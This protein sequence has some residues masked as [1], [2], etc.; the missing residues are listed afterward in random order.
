[1]PKTFATVIE[2]GTSLG[3]HTGS[4]RTIKPE[5]IAGLPPCSATCP[6]G[7]NIQL[8]LSL[9]KAGKFREAWEVMVRDN[10]FPAIMGRICY[11][12]C[13][14]TCCRGQFDGSVNINMIERSI[15]DAAITNGWKFADSAQNSG[16]KIIVVGAGPGGLSAAYFLRK[17]G[18]EVTVYESRAKPGG[19]MRYGVPRY[20]LS[21][22][23]MDAEIKRIEDYGVK[24]I[25]GN[26]ISGIHDDIIGEFDALYAAI[27]AHRAS[28]TDVIMKNGAAVIDAIDL[29]RRLEETPMDLPS[30]GQKVFV[31]GGGNTAVDAA[32]TALRLGAESVKIIYRRTIND[33]P[34]HEIEINAALSE[35]IEILCLRTINSIDGNSILV[36]K[37]NYDEEFEILSKSGDTEVFQADS[38]IF[39]IGQAMDTGFFRDFDAI[40]VTEKGR[41]EVDRNM[42]TQEEGIF[43]GGDIVPGKRSVTTAIGHAKKAARGIDTYVRGVTMPNKTK[44]DVAHFKKLNTVYYRK[45]PRINVSRPNDLSFHEIGV[46][47]SDREI[48][49]Q[50]SRCFSCG[51]CFHCY[52]CYEY[53]PDNAIIKHLDGSL[54]INYNY[55]KGCGICSSEC[56][57]GAIRMVADEKG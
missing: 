18:H 4:W 1:M 33:M 35:G 24:I 32:R 15:G 20:R 3:N 46:S 12:S 8:W 50:A 31:Y 6:A 37:M 44:N 14:K 26:K 23:V 57:C 19:M 51:N 38:V 11:H 53:C 36:D 56:P 55:C 48:V 16:K 21:T 41:I 25:C 42:M 2:A 45:D 52:N 49:R 28:K 47:Y 34:A 29:F 30:F 9:A 10:P 17:L 39:A 54:E 43:A 7:E 40:R 27:G 5:Y 13:E 22:E